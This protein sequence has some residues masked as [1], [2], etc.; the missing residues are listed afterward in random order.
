MG[1]IRVGFVGLGNMGIL[2]ARTL[3][4]SRMPLT[5][6]DLRQAPM[7]EMK[8]LGA[9]PAHSSRE[10]AANSDVIFSVVR[11]EPQNDEVIFGPEGAWQGIKEGST[12]IISSTVSPAYCRRLYTRAREKGVQIIDAPVSTQSRDFTPG[13]E[14]AVF[15]LMIGGDGDAV[16][17]CMPVF[18]ALTKNIFHLGGIG[19]GQACKLVNNLASYGNAVFAR[20][21]LNI[22]LK[23]GL[24]FDQMVAAM[25]VSTGF[26]RGLNT[27]VMQLRRPRPPAPAPS[28]KGQPK[29]LDDKDREFA[30]E[31]AEA[32]RAETPLTRFMTG[33]DLEK[34]YDA[35]NGVISKK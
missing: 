16:K 33:L 32:V 11:D 12:L 30:L 25:R 22:G 7:D 2:M 31:L 5:V 24:D 13:Q 18:E 3:V 21:C 9:I 19:C 27:L 4:K 28:V 34:V 14:S 1:L 17:R 15:T 20:E 35:L 6:Y 10:V 23:A 8:A 26:S 29:S